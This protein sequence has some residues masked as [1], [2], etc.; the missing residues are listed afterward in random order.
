MDEAQRAAAAAA[1]LVED[2]GAGDVRGHQVGGELDTVEP[3]I[4]NLAQAA[5]QQGLG[6]TRDA[7]QQTVTASK[8]GD[9]HL[10]DH[11]FLPD[12]RF[13]DFILECFVDFRDLFEALWQG[14]GHRDTF[15]AV[16]CLGC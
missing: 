6:Q 15:W 8:N 12:N 5:H 9:Q 1:L 13:P 2:F 7:Q 10:V 11:G 16:R 3:E 4:Q 14:Y